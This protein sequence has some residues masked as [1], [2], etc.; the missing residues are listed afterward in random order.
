MTKY[1]NWRE[2]AAACKES[3]MSINGWCKKNNIPGTTCRQ[4]LA[5]IKREEQTSETAE[6]V[7]EPKLWGKVDLEPVKLAETSPEYE[8]SAVGIKLNYHGVSIEIEEG[9]DPILL[10]R[11]LKVVGSIC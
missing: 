2:L 9:F 6:K 7:V 11:V 3:D 8:L 1:E 5:R 10:C 4:W